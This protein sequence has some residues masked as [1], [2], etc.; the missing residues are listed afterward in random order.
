MNSRY[1]E[2]AWEVK[3]VALQKGK[4]IISRISNK[5]DV[6]KLKEIT[7]TITD[8]VSTNFSLTKRQFKTFIK[9]EGFSEEETFS[10]VKENNR[11]GQAE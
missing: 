4:L 1:G 6:L 7:E 9:N 3:K 8:T 5:D 11:G 2:K 10:K